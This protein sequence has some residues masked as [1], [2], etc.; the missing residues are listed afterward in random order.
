[1][2]LQPVGAEG[3][4]LGAIALVQLQVQV[5]ETVKTEFILFYVLEGCKPIWQGELSNCSLIL[6]TNPW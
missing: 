6:G 5:D 1:M 4:S 2:K 3:G